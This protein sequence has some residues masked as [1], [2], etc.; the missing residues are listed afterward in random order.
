VRVEAWAVDTQSSKQVWD[1]K[2]VAVYARERLKELSEA[3]RRK[4]EMQLQVNLTKTMEALGD[5][6]LYE[7]S[8]IST[9]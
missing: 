2:E 1:S 7:G 6:L 4:K 9:L 8:T 5:S 3:N